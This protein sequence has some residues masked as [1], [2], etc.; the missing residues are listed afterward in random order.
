MEKSEMRGY[1]VTALIAFT[2]PTL[3]MA[4]KV[5][6]DEA[7]AANQDRRM[8]ELIVL[9]NT[10]GHISRQNYK[11]LQQHLED[12]HRVVEDLARRYEATEAIAL[13]MEETLLRT[14]DLVRAQGQDIAV[15]KSQK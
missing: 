11:D 1:I 14:K 7:I 6:R 13:R 3:G 8:D 15:L 12:D 5:G 4:T 9:I 2:I 10:E